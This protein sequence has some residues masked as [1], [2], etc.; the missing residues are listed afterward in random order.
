MAKLS[1][2]CAVY[3]I[4]E[5]IAKQAEVLLE[6]FDFQ[7]K[8]IGEPQSDTG[9]QLMFLKFIKQNH[10]LSKSV[11]LNTLRSLDMYMCRQTY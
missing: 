9:N 3:D 8:S 1:D 10:F 7:Y 5:N 2:N 6:S 11:A 4:I